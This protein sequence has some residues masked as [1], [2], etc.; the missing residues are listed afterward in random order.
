MYIYKI[1]GDTLELNGKIWER[2]SMDGCDSS[3]V[4]SANHSE[5]ERQ[6]L[7]E[8]FMENDFEFKQM[9]RNRRKSDEE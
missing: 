1:D 7:F 9:Y 2:V 5:E 6:F 4:S 8:W 3:W